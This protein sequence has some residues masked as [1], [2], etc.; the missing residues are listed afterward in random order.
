[1]ITIPGRPLGKQ[2]ARTIK[3][4][5][6]YTPEQTVNYETFVKICYIEQKGQYLGEIPLRMEINAYYPIPKSTSKKNRAKMLSGEIRPTVKP[7][8][9]NV[10]KS[11]EDGLNNVA[12]KDDNQIITLIAMK[13]YDD[14]PRV[15]ISMYDESI[16]AF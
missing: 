7:D 16:T 15:E 11:I 9:S 12:Y 3:S 4:G 5:R 10:I 1:M 8:L 13:F 6:S 2:R 14:V